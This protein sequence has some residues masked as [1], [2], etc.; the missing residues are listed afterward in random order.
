[1]T[2]AAPV[3]LLPPRGFFHT[4]PPLLRALATCLACRGLKAPG[5]AARSTKL[6][7]QAGA[8]SG[9]ASSTRPV[10]ERHGQGGS[11]HGPR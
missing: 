5:R 4:P 10:E 7:G 1:M 11:G 2:S 3:V 8:S 9:K 6:P